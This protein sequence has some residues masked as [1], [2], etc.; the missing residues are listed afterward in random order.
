MNINTVVEWLD[1]KLKTW[2][3]QHISEFKLMHNKN[4]VEF[5]V[6]CPRLSLNAIFEDWIFFIDE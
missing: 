1:D 5:E 2:S 4:T 6:A 3:N